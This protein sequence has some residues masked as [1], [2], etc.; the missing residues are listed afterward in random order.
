MEKN[1]SIQNAIRMERLFDASP[2]L[3]WR[4]WTEPELVKLWFGSDPKG[5]VLSAELDVHV[6]G[7][8]RIAFQDSDGSRHC[9]KGEYLAVDKEKR[10]LCSW[11]WES[12]PGFISELEVWFL[13]DGAQTKL[14]LEHRN[15]NPDSQHAYEYGW[16]GALDKMQNK[17]PTIK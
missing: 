17:L 2:D 14:I 1:N 5:V 11:E 10:L 3:L 6:G 12:E 15:L 8:Y 9:A 7:Q 4:T 13:P 16:N